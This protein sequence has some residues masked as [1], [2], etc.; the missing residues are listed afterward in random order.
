M[1]QVLKFLEGKKTYAVAILL[2]IAN[3][4]ASLGW[5]TWEQATVA[6]GILAPFGLAFLRAGVDK[7]GKTNDP[8]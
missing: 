3:I 5:F 2:G 7:N 8:K 4:G 6:N 1:A